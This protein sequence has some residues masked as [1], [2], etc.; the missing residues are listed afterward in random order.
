MGDLSR[1]FNRS[2]FACKCG[3]GFDT[4]APDLVDLLQAVR[5]QFGP[6]VITS[7]CRCPEHNRRIGGA[8]RSYHMSGQAAD[9]RIAGARHAAVFEWLRVNY[10]GRFGFILE[11]SWVHIDVRGGAPLRKVIK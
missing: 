7:G 1:N 9:V 6:V 5:D 10:P 2:E 3:C 8:P 4:P 11:P